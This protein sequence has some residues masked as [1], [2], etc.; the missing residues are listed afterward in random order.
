MSDFTLPPGVEVSEIP[1]DC[2]ATRHFLTLLNENDYSAHACIDE[3]LARLDRVENAADYAYMDG[4][5]DGC[6]HDID[7]DL[8]APRA[9]ERAQKAEAALAEARAENQSL[10]SWLLAIPGGSILLA[11]FDNAP[12]AE[13][14]QDE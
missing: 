7:D 9:I 13:G 5:E 6:D 1:N 2:P 11:H 4:V 8:L 3:L 12:P 14:A 10:R